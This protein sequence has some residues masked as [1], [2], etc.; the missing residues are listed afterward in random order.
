MAQ[1]PAQ[2]AC[3]SREIA[4][5]QG[6]PGPYLDQILSAL[7]GAGVVRS[8]RGAGG[9]YSLAKSPDKISVGEIARAMLRGDHLFS[10]SPEE[11]ASEINSPGSSWI[12]RSFEE[13]V[14]QTI[15]RML[16]STTLADLAGQKAVL[17]EALSFMPGI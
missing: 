6:I 10:S 16:D 4:A 15:T 3:Q 13:D 7:K 9:G 8:I 11:G 5:R 14:E 17:D 2:Q 1:H 12:V